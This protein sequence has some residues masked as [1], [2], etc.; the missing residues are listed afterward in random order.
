MLAKLIYKHPELDLVGSAILEVEVSG[1]PLA[2]R[3]MPI[4]KEKIRAYARKRNPFNHM[5]VAF[6]VEIIRSLGGY[7][8]IHLKEDYGLWCKC[9]A[10]DVFMANTEEI[11]VLATTGQEMYKRRGGWQ[12][13]HSEYFLQKL[14]VNLKLK[15]LFQAICDGFIRAIFSLIPARLRGFCY[16]RW[17][18]T[19]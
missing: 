18:R 9:L 4:S 13:V 2:K 11:L 15:T 10:A 17:L 7:P 3:V 5:T 19:N 12:N 6:R 8:N 1:A 14:M 16:L